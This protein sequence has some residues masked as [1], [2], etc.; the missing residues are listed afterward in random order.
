LRVIIAILHATSVRRAQEIKKDMMK[1]R[2]N[3]N[4][5]NAQG[6]RV[7]IAIVHATSVRRA[8]EIRKTG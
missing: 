1:L 2:H 7:I 3:V 8:Q 4:T 6:L 5:S